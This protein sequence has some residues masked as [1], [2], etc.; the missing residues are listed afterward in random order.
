[1]RK[2]HLI[3]LIIHLF[4]ILIMLYI[5]PTENKFFGGKGAIVFLVTKFYREYIICAI[6]F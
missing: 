1:M 4:M 2:L 6:R 5:S 3:Y